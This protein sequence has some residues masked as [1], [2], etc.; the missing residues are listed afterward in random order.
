[1]LSQVSQSPAGLFSKAYR[2]IFEFEVV[3][4]HGC[5]VPVKIAHVEGASAQAFQ[6]A[7]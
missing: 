1:M 6:G 3:A 7:G 4:I 5:G 2:E